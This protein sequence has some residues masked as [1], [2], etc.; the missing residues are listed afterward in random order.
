[1]PYYDTFVKD[2]GQHMGVAPAH[3]IP[4]LVLVYGSGSGH[5]SLV[6]VKIPHSVQ[7]MEEGESSS[8]IPRIVYLQGNG[9]LLLA[10]PG[11]VPGSGGL[12]NPEESSSL[13]DLPA[14]RNE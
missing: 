4:G 2:P 7:G 9:R 13:A 1:M 6:H 5:N 14:A 12:R 10:S 3:L 8:P 11:I